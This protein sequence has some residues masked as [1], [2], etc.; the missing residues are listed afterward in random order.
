VR[1]YKFTGKERDAESGLDNF[2]GVES[3]VGVRVELALVEAH[4]FN[5]VAGAGRFLDG[6]P[7]IVVVASVL[8]W[9]C[10]TSVS[11]SSSFRTKNRRKRSFT[12]HL[13]RWGNHTN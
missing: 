12:S 4:I 3:V 11:Y 10:C 5:Q 6:K 9:Y 1:R 8:A 13:R 2:I 7:E